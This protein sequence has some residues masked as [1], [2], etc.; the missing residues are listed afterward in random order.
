MFVLW[1]LNVIGRYES[2]A[3]KLRLCRLHKEIPLRCTYPLH[4]ACAETTP[5]IHGD[6]LAEWNAE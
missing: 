2:E 5:P 6:N 4:E 1:V 3:E